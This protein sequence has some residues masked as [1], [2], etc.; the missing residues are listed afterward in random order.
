MKIVAIVTTKNRL[1]LL[2]KALQSISAQKRKPDLTIVVSDSS[3]DCDS[4]KTLCDQIGAILLRDAFTHNYAGSLNTA[5]YYLLEQDLF[6][7][8]DYSRTYI[9]T[10]DDDDVWDSDYLYECECA[11]KDGQDFAVCGLI[12]FDGQ[13]YT[14]FPIPQALSTET[15]LQ[16]NPNLQGS[17]TFVKMQTLLK[18][19]LFDENVCSATD[20][21]L[22]VRIM[23]LKPTFVVINRH[24]VTADVSNNRQ[25][26]TNS[27]DKKIQGYRSFLYKY[28]G[29]MSS[30]IRENFF[31]HAKNTFGIDCKQLLCPSAAQ[32][33]DA[34]PTFDGKYDGHLTIGMIATDATLA[35]R[36][37]NEIAALDRPNTQVVVLV[38]T[39]QNVETLQSTAK[40]LNTTLLTRE[41]LSQ[42]KR[43]EAKT[44]YQK[45]SDGIISDIAVARGILQKYIYYNTHADDVVWIL[46]DDMEL[47]EIVGDN[48]RTI[49]ID[50][51]IAA[52]RNDYDAVVGNYC[53]DAPLPTL[54]TVRSSLLDYVY[55]K[56]LK[57][58]EGNA[59]RLE[60]DYYDLSE[61][62]RRRLETPYRVD[63]NTTLDDVFS[64]KAQARKLTLKNFE[65]RPVCNRG[66][67]T[68]IFNR[69]LLLLP[70]ISLQ[71]GDVMGRRS[72]YFWTVFARQKGFKLVNVPFAT[73]HNRS[74]QP[75]E[76]AKEQNKL[77]KD[78]IGA[79]FTHAYEILPRGGS[80]YMFFEKYRDF[81]KRRLSKYVANIYRVMGLLEIVGD[82]KY[83]TMLNERTLNEFTEQA[84]SYVNFVEVSTAY[85]TFCTKLSETELPTDEICKLLQTN[86]VS[87]PLKLLGRGNE[88]LVVCDGEF[89][90]KVFCHDDLDWN[91]LKEIA[92][93]F[94]ECRQLYPFELFRM[95]NHPIIKYPFEPS[96]KYTGG[97]ADE[98]AELIRFGKNHGFVFNNFK[99]ENFIVA[100]GRLKMIDYG[101]S[102]RP[103]NEEEYR[104]SIKRAFQTVRY[105]FLTEDEF[106]KIVYLS[107]RGETAFVDFGSDLFEHLVEPRSKEQQ[108]D[109]LIKQIVDNYRP[110]A[111]L[112]YGAGKCKIANALAEQYDV[113][114]FDIDTE[115]ICRRASKKV[116]VINSIETIGSDNFDMII[117]NL[118]LCCVNNAVADEIVQNI[119]RLLKVGGRA[120][121]SICHPFFDQVNVTELRLQGYNG[122]YC[123]SA[124]FEKHT[125]FGTVREDFHRPVEFY[126]NLLQRNGL[127]VENIYE[128]SGVDADSLMP[129]GEQ[130]VFDCRLDDKPIDLHDCSLMIKTN[131]MEHAD[132]YS[133]I[134][135][136]VGQLEK[137]L[138]F[139]KRIVVADLTSGKRVRMY[140]DDNADKLCNE[141]QRAK[142]NGLIDEMIL[143]EDNQR[144]QEIYTEYFGK[145]CENSHSAN[146]QGLYATLLGFDGIDTRY[147]LHS[148]SDILYNNCDREGIVEALH[149]LQ[150]AVVA[151]IGIPHVSSLPP[152]F[153][154]RVEVRSCFVDLEKLHRLLP[155]EN[156]IINGCFE[157]PWHRALDARLSANDSVRFGNNKC[158]FV[159][160]QNSLKTI[161]N[162]IATCREAMEQNF[163][164]KLQ[165]D[166]VDLAGERSDWTPATDSEMIV[167]CRGYN[168]PC[169]KVKRALDSLA[170]QS[171]RDFVLIYIDDAST[172]ESGQYA[173][174]LLTKDKRFCSKS[175]GLFNNSRV[176]ELDNMVFA[177][178]NIIKNPEA[179]VVCLD[180]DD[181]F[182]DDAALERIKAE[183]D[184]GAD[185]TCGNCFR[186]DKPLKT[187]RVASFQ[188]VWERQGDNVWLHPK[189]FRR[190]LFDKIDIE[191]DLKNNGKFYTINTDFAFVLP[192]LDNA[193]CRFI[194]QILYYFEP[195][196]DNQKNAG[197]YK[198]EYKIEVKQQILEKAKERYKKKHLT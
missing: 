19:G 25:R 184:K 129:I 80:V 98:I 62:E 45:Y 158:R 177:M 86:G 196:A 71:I 101:N 181:C 188:N 6:C 117:N 149:S 146:G 54:S 173:H 69:D 61:I 23:L 159:H 123:R 113:S 174:M 166:K 96:E 137:G 107:Y 122:T 88:G 75:F 185:Y 32:G 18:A 76:F 5:L 94:G 95:G 50:G 138:R 112:D 190:K 44:A 126:F 182:V 48:I 77:L 33:N 150:N 194:P 58:D 49:N 140:A 108:H 73:L 26:I 42:D 14:S 135:H 30:Q 115:T 114:V 106:K 186:Y 72:D 8:H 90:Y 68:L 103:F 141:L 9:A 154:K 164:P 21:D 60:D 121:V 142:D 153:G 162:L 53:L 139:A 89:V 84:K 38:N 7:P 132:I 47:K 168:T 100:N 157:L 12:F 51:V 16:T 169:S 191:N 178:Q 39:L 64:G 171:F 147:V 170:R 192:M 148:D 82:V 120:I 91:F 66:G 109:E 31:E 193:A 172:N 151:S 183:F 110:S 59:E 65:P 127:I 87:K 46:D 128:T 67:N 145:A 116:N 37:I 55:T 175:I 99:K 160:P 180:N 81:F 11:V 189:C 36:L 179:I 43:Y 156:N 155:L 165:S 27:I 4:E 34:P 40:Q 134:V 74:K 102:L 35:A 10:L 1:E 124:K 28:G 176:G 152:T 133:S 105:P 111:I 63:A 195:S 78:I 2:Q 125:K 57:L 161:P 144:Q 56:Y 83:S 29:L 197:D 70:N 92:A 52:Y 97:H 22:F 79:A 131:P 119:T 118:V 136:I 93:C 24:L 130:L 198:K 167:F 41:L 15:F 143:A 187:Y 163:I 20:R 13:K 104:I 85:K 17:N 3:T